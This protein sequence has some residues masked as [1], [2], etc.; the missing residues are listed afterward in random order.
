LQ[1]EK[2]QSSRQLNK[3][4]LDQSQKIEFDSLTGKK[5]SLNLPETQF[6]KRRQ[7]SSMG[8]DIFQSN[9]G[10]PAVK[11]RMPFYYNM[12]TQIYNEQIEKEAMGKNPQG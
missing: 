4:D 10:K 2:L 5:I 9:G 12:M 3:K 1:K 7:L 6:S 8:T 11:K